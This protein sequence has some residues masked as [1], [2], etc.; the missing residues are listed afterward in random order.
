MPGW[1]QAFADINPVTKAVDLGR[2]LT[3][4]GPIIPNARATAAWT[5]GMASRHRTYRRLEISARSKCAN[6]PSL[7]HGI[8]LE[9][10]PDLIGCERVTGQG[11]FSPTK[12]QEMSEGQMGVTCNFATDERIW[13]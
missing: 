10:E 13:T 7:L 2:A 5:I 4:G 11:R 3:Q 6:I 1:L 9:P 8:G 12:W